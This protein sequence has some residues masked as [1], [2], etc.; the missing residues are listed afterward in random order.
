[1]VERAHDRFGSDSDRLWRPEPQPR[2]PRLHRCR[3]PLAPRRGRSAR[4]SVPLAGL[5]TALFNSAAPIAT[6]QEWQQHF[7]GEAALDTFG[8]TIAV[9]GDLDGDSVDDLL[10]GAPNSSTNAWHGG[11]AYAYSGATRTLLATWRGQ[12]LDDALGLALCGPGDLDGDGV[13]ELLIGAPNM[14]GGT[15][16]G[17][18]KLYSGATRALLRTFDGAV[19]GDAFGSSIAALA[20]QT[21]DGVPE[22]AIGAPGA[23]AYFIYDGA[24][25]GEVGQFTSLQPDSS[26]GNAIA[27]AD[28]LDHDGIGDFFVSAPF[29]RD[30]SGTVVGRLQLRSGRDGSVLRNHYGENR[31]SFMVDFYGWTAIAV[32]DVD[33]DGVRDYATGAWAFGSCQEGRIYVYSG[34]SGLEIGRYDGSDCGDLSGCLLADGGDLDGDGSGDLLVGHPQHGSDNEGQLELLAALDGSELS[35]IDGE[36]RTR[37][38]AGIAAAADLDHDGAPDLLVASIGAATT[39]VGEVDRYECHAPTVAA[40]SLARAD[41]RDDTTVTLTGSALRAEAGLV[42]ELD[43]ERVPDLVPLDS[44]SCQFRV[45]P[46]APGPVVL[47]VATRFGRVELTFLRTPAITLSGSLAP[48]GSGVWSSHVDDGDGLLLI[49]GIPPAQPTA[50]PPYRGKLALLPYFVVALVPDVTGD[51]FD[52]P[53]DIADDPALSG[54]TLLVQA[55]AG[56][57]LGGKGKDAGWTNWIEFTIE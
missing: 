16:R 27:P 49:A 54:V 30:S 3:R 31:S 6:A 53:F 10:I 44:T 46:G 48:G 29:W 35:R 18:V 39:Y 4:F 9:V 37:L 23:S 50:T 14:I 42:V 22:I 33:R 41:H 36:P 7:S 2:T 20:D 34:Q 13:G 12:R 24:N 8:T 21:G 52:L 57:K 17:Q 25:G 55:L 56:P 38:G 11:A 1:M 51:R 15:I 5:V 45:P 47:A 26:L 19:P 43:G 32:T 28:D 40:L